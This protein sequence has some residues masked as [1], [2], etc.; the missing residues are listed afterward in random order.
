MKGNVR[1][2]NCQQSFII[3][4]K[5]NP[6]F[7]SCY[8]FSV[9]HTQRKY[10]IN[11]YICMYIKFIIT[12]NKGLGC[13]NFVVTFEI[14]LSAN[15]LNMLYHFFI[16]FRLLCMFDSIRTLVC[17]RNPWYS[18]KSTFR[19]LTQSIIKGVGV[20]SRTKITSEQI[21][22]NLTINLIKEKPKIP[23][24]ISLCLQIGPVS[25]FILFAFGISIFP[26]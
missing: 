19:E 23:K 15:M 10:Y 16:S 13:A 24:K 6:S 14:S 1:K 4:I 22:Q 2:L 20:I 8:D 18:Q 25:L 11:N 12:A 26:F 7:P 3:N 9:V 21:T 17:F 5:Q